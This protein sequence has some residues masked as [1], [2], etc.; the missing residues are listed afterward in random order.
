MRGRGSRGFALAV[1]LGGLARIALTAPAGPAPVA[2]APS[3]FVGAAACGACHAAKHRLW[4]SGRHSR[5]LQPASEQSVLGDFSRG[6]LRL[7]GDTYALARKGGAFTITESYLGGETRER[8]VDY[9]LGSRRIQH[10][11]TRLDD[12]RIVVLPPSW[13]VRRRDWF[14]NLEIVAPRD[15]EPAAARKVQVWNS[16]CVGCHVSQEEKN[17]DPAR[18]VY[19][20]RWMD[21]GTSCERCHGPGRAHAESPAAAM[22]VASRLPPDR[23]T[24]VCAQCHSLRDV[25]AAGFAAGAD[26]FD[27]FLPVLEY[28]QKE[29]PDPPY[30]PDGR[31][32]RFSN[33]AIGLWQ[34]ACFVKGGATCTTCHLDP[35]LPD[36]DKNPQL[37]PSDNKL[38]LSCHA[39]IGARLQAHTRHRPESAGSACVECHMPP[40][41]VS[42]KARMRDHAISV[43]SPEAAARF[44]VPDACTTCH[45]GKGAQ[46][47]RRALQAWGVKAPSRTLR[48]AAAFQGARRGDRG[49]VDALLALSADRDEPPLVRANAVGHLRSFD[50]PRV[51]AALLAALQDPHPLPRAVA[52][53]TLAESRAAAAGNERLAAALSDPARV[54]RMAAAF[55]LVNRRVTRLPGEDG[56]RLQEA[57]RD[58]LAR[59]D[60][61]LDHAPTQL[62][63]GKLL[64]LD[65]DAGGAASSI[66]AALKLDP[67]LPGARY[68]LAVSLAAAGRDAEARAELRRVPEGDPFFDAARKMAGKL[69]RR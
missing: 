34:S 51:S 14:H 66:G 55:A 56:R 21:F 44:G 47:A 13:D 48:R 67:V 69:E 22:V 24:A 27:H 53:F 12:G 32:R 57:T 64:L 36:V 49:A 4:S 58:H 65:G 7:Q 59:A 31:P 23:A 39:P 26:Y 28:G 16:G 63:R 43:P 29:G 42:I 25:S 17:Y 3:P 60:L 9:T 52:A 40:T 10:Y 62:D 2:P 5:M 46:W 30:W 61:L 11:L 45:E 8:R 68:L 38:C 15:D 37:A 54:V 6:R 20:T 19:E 41:V 35:H 50:E 18:A 1:A 33:D